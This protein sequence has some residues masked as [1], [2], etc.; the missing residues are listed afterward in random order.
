MFEE[1]TYFAFPFLV[2]VGVVIC[3]SAIHLTV[4]GKNI[5]SALKQI[6]PPNLQGIEGNLDDCSTEL[7]KIRLKAIDF[8]DKIEDLSY[9]KQP[10]DSYVETKPID[11]GSS[12][13]YDS[14]VYFEKDEL[15]DDAMPLPSPYNRYYVDLK[16]RVFSCASNKYD[17]FKKLTSSP[18][19]IYP[20]PNYGGSQEYNRIEMSRKRLFYELFVDEIPE[21][22]AVKG[23]PENFDGTYTSNLSLKQSNQ[24][25][26]QSIYGHTQTYVPDWVRC[27]MK[28][29]VQSPNQSSCSHGVDRVPD[30]LIS[31]P[32]PYHRYKV[33]PQGKVFSCASPQVEGWKEMDSGYISLSPSTRDGD[34]DEYRTIQMRKKRLFFELFVDRVPDGSCVSQG[35]KDFDRYYIETL[36][37][38]PDTR[39][40][41]TNDSWQRYVPSYIRYFLQ[42]HFEVNFS[43]LVS[44][45][46]GFL[47]QKD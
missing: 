21:G 13:D 7:Q 33:N 22:Y 34:D 18:F 23:P 5:L 47:Q 46:E 43:N 25:R 1:L 8:V 42:G 27:E 37:L 26:P 20:T 41:Y 3:V 35:G 11:T 6:Q 16:G 15:P 17:G 31:L 39:D 4:I 30:N 12:I 40:Q 45:P 9:P 29:K 19:T 44:D 38:K 36:C 24:N 32:Y 28:N 14:K 2:V 10:D